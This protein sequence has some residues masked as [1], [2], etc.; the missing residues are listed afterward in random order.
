M[1]HFENGALRLCH[2]ANITRARGWAVS[3]DEAPRDYIT[4]ANAPPR[5]QHL[6]DAL[7]ALGSAP[8]MGVDAA[9]R[10]LLDASRQ[11][12]DVA[13]ASFW[14][15]ALDGQSLH[16]EQQAIG[17]GMDSLL[18]AVVSAA[19]APRYFQA[20]G[21]TLTLAA[22]DVAVD[23][24]TAELIDAYLR[25]AGIGALLD[26]GVRVSGRLVGVVCH[27]HIGG[28]R[29]WAAEERLFV[30]AI[31][32]M[33][34]RQ[35][36]HQRL[37]DSEARRHLA[38]RMDRL[39]GLPNRVAL[40]ERVR[41]LLGAANTTPSAL[42]V[43][44]IDRF[45]RINHAHGGELGDRVLAALSQRLAALF[46]LEDLARL[47]NDQFVVLV[48]AGDVDRALADIRSH[49]EGRSLFPDRALSVTLSIGVVPSLAGYADPD[50]VLRDAM[51][52]ADAA[53]RGPRSGMCVFDADRHAAAADRLRL[54]TELR[55]AVKA[56]EFAFYLQPIVTLAEHRL[57][58][59]EALL[60]WQHPQAGLLAP[61]DFLESAEETELLGAIH[62]QLLPALL[63]QLA[64]WRKH[65]G[66]AT[67][68]L[69]INA[70][71]SQ[72]STRE[73]VE[74]WLTMLRVAGL[75]RQA[76]QIEITENT[77]LDPG[78]P[79]E[80]QL[81]YLAQQGVALSMDDFGTGFASIS[82]LARLP[83][84]SMKIDRSFVER[85]GSDARATNLVR[86]LLDMARELGLQVVAEGVETANQLALLRLLGCAT[87]QGYLLGVP[88]PVAEFER[89]WMPTASSRTAHA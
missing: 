24:R 11:A 64:Q 67:F 74:R 19:Q 41:V 20:L 21:C 46:E 38:L 68:Q 69:H 79:I 63:R 9:M 34:A 44:D 26:V 3:G 7:F 1:R 72:L 81:H 5:W 80:R 13:R 87:A 53:S 17:E 27:E 43:L 18:G 4:P 66:M 54:E 29:T 85:M 10:Q 52:A 37:I 84:A 16:C 45:H 57:V 73:A 2:E 39:S 15:L 76:I 32:A 88:L 75:E 40:L 55:Q 49:L 12:L 62:A 61:G 6:R 8:E 28:A 50:A 56:S 36:E 35:F 83:L 89:V 30:A 65:P 71:A 86:V 48:P 78:S 23:E 59:A 22:E 82:H 42:L 77:L 58:G 14:R 33:A 51:I 47:G 31:S 25:P 60:R 70:A